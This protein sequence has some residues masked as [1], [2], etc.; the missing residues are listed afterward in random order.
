MASVHDVENF[1]YTLNTKMR[2]NMPE[3]MIVNTRPENTQTL[4]DLEITMTDQLRVIKS[5]KVTQ[6]SS[7]PLEDYNKQRNLIWW[8][9]G[10][11]IKKKEVYI[12]ISLNELNRPPIC[13]S[14]HI[15]TKKLFYPFNNQ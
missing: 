12:K 11:E 14:F 6:Y 9:F 15:A 7:G 5:L 4:A 1:L 2:L 10:A 8:V 13:L 3:I